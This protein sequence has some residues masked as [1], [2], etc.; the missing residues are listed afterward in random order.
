MQIDH[1]PNETPEFQRRLAKL[2][3]LVNVFLLMG[4][5]FVWKTYWGLKPGETYD[6]RNIPFVIA[7]LFLFSW[8]FFPPRI[9]N[10]V[11]EESTRNSI[12]FRL[13]KLLNGVLRR[14][15]G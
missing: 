11:T 14:L 2:I 6:W 8:C 5:W 15:R 10:G 9:E 4:G 13:G 1:D 7:F 3:I 12:A